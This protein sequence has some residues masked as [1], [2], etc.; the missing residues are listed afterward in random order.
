LQ[1]VAA[2]GK[3]TYEVC[4][5]A[6]DSHV[7]NM[8]VADSRDVDIAVASARN[9]FESGDWSKFTGAQRAKCM[10]KF[11][12]LLETEGA[13]IAELESRS[14]GMPIG[15]NKG[16]ILPICVNTFRCKKTGFRGIILT[17]YGSLCRSC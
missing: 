2:S 16:M 14:M 7:G 12:D 11:A 9:A 3:S 6:D 5:P 13:K 1:Y 8:A 10:L 4:N 15:L 17:D